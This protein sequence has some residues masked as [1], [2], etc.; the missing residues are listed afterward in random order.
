MVSNLAI[1]YIINPKPSLQ[2]HISLFLSTFP[3]QSPYLS[4][5]FSTSLFPASHIRLCLQVS[6]TL[7]WIRLQEYDVKP[8]ASPPTSCSVRLHENDVHPQ[9]YEHEGD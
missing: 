6:T 7:R 2:D 3:S 9:A 8:Q 5:F 1:Y 4:L